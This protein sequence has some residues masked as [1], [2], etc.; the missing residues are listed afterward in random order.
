[1]FCFEMESYSSVDFRQMLMPFLSSNFQYRDQ[2]EFYFP[3]EADSQ[4]KGLKW[5]TSSQETLVEIYYWTV[6]FAVTLFFAAGF[7]AA[8]VQFFVSF[9]RANYTVRTNALSS[10][11]R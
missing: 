11:A 1:M 4:P 9:F 7:L 8:I 5:M 10:E 3:P 2:G 6:I